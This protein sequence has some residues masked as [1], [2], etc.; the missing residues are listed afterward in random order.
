MEK[1][2]AQNALASVGGSAFERP[3]SNR[4]AGDRNASGIWAIDGDRLVSVEDFD[5]G[6]A[7]VLVQSEQVLIL[8]VELPPMA[9]LARRRAAL[10][11]A[12]EDRI[13]EPVEDVHVA[14]GAQI[15][16][17]LHLAAVVRHD[18]MRRWVALL[19]AA[20]LEQA[21]LVPD[22]MAL[23]VP[24]A[25]TW[26]VDMAGQ[27]AVVRLEDHTGFAMPLDLLEPTWQ[28]AG[29]PACVA[30]GDP[31]PPDLHAGEAILE[32]AP[33]AERLMAPD[34]D[35]RQ[36][37]Y[38]AP[39][40]AIDPLWKRVATVAAI[41]ALAHAA[42]AAADTMVLSNM[43]D[44]REA[45]VRQL[46]Q[47]VAPS[48]TLGPDL[49]TLVADMG[50]A[51]SGA[52]PS[53]FLALVSTAGAAFA[54]ANVPVTW[55]S[56]SYDKAGETLSLEIETNDAAGLQRVA[57]ALGEAGMDVRPGAVAMVEGRAV[58]SFA[59]SAK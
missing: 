9:G 4:A 16:R 21:A 5:E 28:S 14:L 45:Q 27:R 46:A 12:L 11:F 41:G 56:V 58:G 47:N 13:A 18:L 2:I 26:S 33:L 37:I 17:N 22:C 38:A 25:G 7:I 24:G 39:R 3:V 57:S 52:A 59:I 23:P 48:L 30:Y 49:S 29:T 51:Q 53:Q 20:G 15:A 31:L 19:K 8:A 44:A 40:K 42:I 36:G 34:I 54:K 35:L 10:P 1:P 55:R 43:A 6:P 50:P 32:S